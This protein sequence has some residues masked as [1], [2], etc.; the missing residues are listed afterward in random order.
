MSDGQL[1]ARVRAYDREE[2][3]GPR[4]VANELAGT[5]Q[6]EARHRATAQ[7]RAAEAAAAADPADRARLEREATDAGALA[8]VLDTQ[9]RQLDAADE[10]RALWLVHT[11]ETRAAADRARLEISA[12]DIASGRPEEELTTAEEWLAAQAEAQRVED[13]H[14]RV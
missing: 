9:A 2:P 10:A 1:H 5:R 3:W 11:A 7:V 6:A 4:Y 14:R 8:D 12:R 13:R